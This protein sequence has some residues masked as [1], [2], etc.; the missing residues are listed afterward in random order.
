MKAKNKKTIIIVAAMVA[1]AAL[2]WWL[3]W[4][5]KNTI[6]GVIN[7]LED[8]D[9]TMKADLKNRAKQVKLQY[10]SDPDIKFAC[11]SM[12]D[13]FGY[14]KAQTFVMQA[15]MFLQSE[16]KYNITINLDNQKD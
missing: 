3:V 5:K 11:D 2:V 13:T 8:M 16:G 7:G 9:E 10:S 14:T 15:A 6:D 1:V 12:M 4:R